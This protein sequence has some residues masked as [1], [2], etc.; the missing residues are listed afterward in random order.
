MRRILMYSVLLVSQGGCHKQDIAEPHF[1]LDALPDLQ[2]EA[3]IDVT[4]KDT[5]PAWERRYFE[6]DITFIPIEQLTPSP[7]ERLRREIENHAHGLAELPCKV[8]LDLDLF[9]VVESTDASL[10]R[11][12]RIFV[13][14]PD[15]PLLDHGSV[16]QTAVS[17]SDAYL[18]VFILGLY[19]TIVGAADVGILTYDLAVA[20]WRYAHY[21]HA[22][23][24]ELIVDYPAGL[25]CDIRARATLE[26]PDGKSREIDLHALVTRSDLG[27][28]NKGSGDRAEDIRLIVTAACK[29]L[30]E[31]FRERILHP[32]LP[33][34]L[35]PKRPLPVWTSYSGN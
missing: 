9:R 19:V 32:D 25:T 29:A 17:C 8:S 27:S 22:K 28:Q 24:R 1:N 10:P 20:A 34:E 7:A 26:W 2:V 3:P 18:E 30:G 13:G 12:E 6:G 11:L 4:I 21:S 16:N 35:G 23:P 33:V 15:K 5:R 14:F 31:E